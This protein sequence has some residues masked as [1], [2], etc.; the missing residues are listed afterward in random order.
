VTIGP[1]FG[2]RIIGS[3]RGHADDLVIGPGDGAP[4]LVD[5]AG[6]PRDFLR[7]N[8]IRL[9]FSYGALWNQWRGTGRPLQVRLLDVDGLELNLKRAPTAAPIG[10]S[11]RRRPPP[12][13][14]LQ[15]CPGSRPWSCATAK[16]ASWTS[17]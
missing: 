9:A 4:A 16:C 10:S 6:Q 5:E 3:V 8:R 17:R 13:R 15:R 11:A 14:A 2:V 1:D 12:L 7:A